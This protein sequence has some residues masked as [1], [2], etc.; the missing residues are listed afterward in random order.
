MIIVDTNVLS[1]LVRPHPDERVTAWFGAHGVEELW[2]TATTEAEM[3]I[4]LAVMPAGRRKAELQSAIATVLASFESRILPFDRD[5]AR[6]LAS[7]Y[8]ERRMAGREPK[9]VDSQIAAIARVHGS[10]VATRDVDD[11][12]HS[13]ID[14]INPWT[15][16]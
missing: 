2:T 5:A 10:A 8:L 4:G 9:F 12:E 11:F 3:L 1:E 13:G 6:E 16:T 15:A 14:I 7:V